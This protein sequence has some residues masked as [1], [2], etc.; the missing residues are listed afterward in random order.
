MARLFGAQRMVLQA[1]QDSFKDAAGFVTDAQV[2][3]G[4]GIALKDVR[5]WIETL[6]GEDFV[7]VA[8]TTAGVTASITAKGRIQ[9]SLYEPIPPPHGGAEGV[10]ATEPG[11]IPSADSPSPSAAEAVS[12]P[13]TPSPSFHAPLTS[14]SSEPGTAL[15]NGAVDEFQVV[16]LIHG[17][18]TQADWGPMVKSKIEVPGQIQVIPIKYGYFD[19]FRFW[20]PFWTRSKPVERV[21]VQIRVAL[22]K[23]RKEHPDAKLS[24]IAHSFGTYVVGQILKREF[25]LKIH[26]LILCGSVLP[27]DFPWHDYQGRFDDNNVVNECG[28]SDIWPVLAQ[29]T[30]WGY[31]AS[32][33]HGFGAVLVKDR[34]HAGGHGQYFAPDFVEGYWEPFIRRNE[35]MGTEFETKMPTTPW[36]LSLIGILSLTKLLYALIV[37]CVII[38]AYRSLHGNHGEQPSAVHTKS[39]KIELYQGSIDDI[40][41]LLDARNGINLAQIERTCDQKGVAAEDKKRR[42]A[43]I[44]ELHEKVKNAYRSRNIV[45]AHELTNSM[46]RE[47]DIQSMTNSS[48]PLSDAANSHGV[49]MQL[50]PIEWLVRQFATK[51]SELLSADR[52]RQ[53]YP[54]Y[55]ISGVDKGSPTQANGKAKMVGSNQSR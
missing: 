33:T 19:A 40:V 42:I 55:V 51:S 28:K 48:T 18:R 27:Q 53:Q 1:V 9:L 45:L 5:D 15:P 17:I 32:G 8:Q 29:S 21:Y 39:E 38:F 23:Y 52:L 50:K 36:W 43:A 4:T 14:A 47:L 20:F 41:T 16:L 34:F 13:I 25:D 11:Q 7:E 44:N 54:K 6:E 3:Q 22:Q 30:S 10:G 2:A 46:H 12:P 37:L 31:G 26:R 24:I 49:Y 35:Y